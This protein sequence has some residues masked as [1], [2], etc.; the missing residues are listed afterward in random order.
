M[1]FSYGYGPTIKQADTALAA[2]KSQREAAGQR[3]ARGE[4][5]LGL[6][7]IPAGRQQDK[8]SQTTDTVAIP[9]LD[10]YAAAKGSIVNVK[11][12]S[13]KGKTVTVKEDAAEALVRIDEQESLAQRLLE[14]LST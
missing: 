13:L 1:N 4:K 6:V 2:S 7:K 14:C 12:V 3:A 9:A 11:A 10:K 5:P 8:G